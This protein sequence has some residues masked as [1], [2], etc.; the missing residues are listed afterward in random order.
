MGEADRAIWGQDVNAR[1]E[2]YVQ[3]CWVVEVS[4]LD[5]EVGVSSVFYE[6]YDSPVAS[7]FQRLDLLVWH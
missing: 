3:F 5:G 2:F 1:F 7:D 6:C 4:V